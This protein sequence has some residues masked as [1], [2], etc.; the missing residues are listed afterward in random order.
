MDD[1]SRVTLSIA[2]VLAGIV[3]AVAAGSLIT[4]AETEQ[5]RGT[6]IDYG[7]RDTIWVETDV[8]GYGTTL[9]LLES[10][11][12]S[13]GLALTIADDGSI[14]E[15]GPTP[16]TPRSSPSRHGPTWQRA[17][18]PRWPSTTPGTRSTG[19]SRS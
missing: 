6:V 9:E 16:R 1:R 8:T 17:T 15:L 2:I 12:G 7:D 11:C 4:E 18:S 5:A 3:L 10:A 19:T 13:N 14:T